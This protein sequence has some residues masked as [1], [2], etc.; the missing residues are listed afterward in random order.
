MA[1]DNVG[2][3]MPLQDEI[4]KKIKEEISKDP[5]GVG[6]AGKSDAEIQELLNNPVLKER[7]EVYSL[8]SPINRILSG[9]AFAPNIIDETDVSNA[10]NSE[11]I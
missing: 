10:K 7:V 2:L 3:T 9:L 5:Y 4:K 6:Y 8:P 1:G 11:V